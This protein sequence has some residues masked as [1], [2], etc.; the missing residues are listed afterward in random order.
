MRGHGRF[1]S[2]TALIQMDVALERGLKV[3]VPCQGL[4]RVGIHARFRTKA[5][6]GVSNSVSSIRGETGLVDARPAHSRGPR[7]E[8][9]RRVLGLRRPVEPRPLLQPLTRCALC[10]F[11][12]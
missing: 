4:E 7:G 1:C 11:C 2:G 6:H 12:V 3:R 9:A 5:Q 10:A 8:A